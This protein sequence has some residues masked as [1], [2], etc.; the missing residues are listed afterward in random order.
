[1]VQ[2]IIFL[3]LLSFIVFFSIRLSWIIVQRSV[4]MMLLLGDM[5]RELITHICPHLSLCLSLRETSE[6]DDVPAGL[7]PLSD[8]DSS[9]PGPDLPSGQKQTVWFSLQS[10]L[11]LHVPPDGSQNSTVGCNQTNPDHWNRTLP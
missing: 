6:D 10:H 9:Q 8:S 11:G 5:N 3:L 1:M 2:M 7:S 4:D